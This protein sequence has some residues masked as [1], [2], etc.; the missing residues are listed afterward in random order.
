VERERETGRTNQTQKGELA[1]VDRST[2]GGVCRTGLRISTCERAD[3]CL[4]SRY[5]TPNCVCVCVCVWPGRRE[6]LTMLFYQFCFM[7]CVAGIDIYVQFHWISQWVYIKICGRLTFNASFSNYFR[8]LVQASLFW[9]LFKVFWCIFCFMFHD[10]TA[11]V[12]FVY[13]I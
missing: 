8:C 4:Y 10:S 9:I 1:F 12:Y 3:R 5:T 2:E 11:Y 7:K 6:Y 13:I